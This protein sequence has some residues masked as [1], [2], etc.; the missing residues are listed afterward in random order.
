MTGRPSEGDIAWLGAVAY[1]ALYDYWAMKNHRETLSSSWYRATLDPKRRW[2]TLLLPLYL[3]AHLL[4]RIPKHL[5]PLRRWT[6][7]STFSTPPKT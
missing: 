4:R 5:D 1:I 6:S 2:P 3:Y 7:T